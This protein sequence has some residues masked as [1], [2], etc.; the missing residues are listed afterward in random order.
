MPV[1]QWTE[2]PSVSV[3]D[4][5]VMLDGVSHVTLEGI[6][7]AHSKATG[8]SA[9]RVSDVLLS[10]CTVYGHGANGVTIDDALRS[11]IVDSHVYDVGCIGVTLSG[12]NHTSLE[13]GLNFALRN[14][15]HHMANFKRT[16]QPV[17]KP[18]RYLLLFCA[19]I[20]TLMGALL[21]TGN[22]LVRGEQHD[23]P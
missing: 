3:G 15:I 16:Y 1:A 21:A 14:R 23:K 7:V 8:I 11:G 9:R 17:R 2:D 12:G 20:I 13:P 10:N 18:E 19:V 4:I 6:S 22:T 5:G